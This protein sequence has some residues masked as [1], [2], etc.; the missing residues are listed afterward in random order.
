MQRERGFIKEK[1][2]ETDWELGEFFTV[3]K[4]RWNGWTDEVTAVAAF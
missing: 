2:I 3:E 4:D 1:V